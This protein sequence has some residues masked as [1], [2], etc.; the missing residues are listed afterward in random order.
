MIAVDWCLH[1]QMFD[2]IKALEEREFDMHEVLMGLQEMDGMMPN[3]VDLLRLRI[4]QTRE[5][6]I[7]IKT[8][9]RIV[10]CKN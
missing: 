5:K 8:V 2:A 7:L 1:G 9:N 3:T 4:A 10:I 6:K